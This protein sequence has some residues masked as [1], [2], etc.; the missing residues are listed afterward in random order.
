[1]KEPIVLSFILYALYVLLPLVPTV[2]IY[3]MFPNT[4]VAVSGPLANFSVNATGAFAAYIV[5]VL[6]GW[7]LVSEVADMIRTRERV[8]WNVTGK[9]V[10]T[11]PS[12]G[13]MAGDSQKRKDL[14]KLLQVTV[15]P[16]QFWS[17]EDAI[18]AKTTLNERE[19]T[20]LTYTIP[21]FGS[22][23]RTPN[24]QNASWDYVTHE[25]TFHDPIKIRGWQ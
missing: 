8:S 18:V 3:R 9:L 17:T 13:D 15:V 5:T 19:P 1:M 7:F 12:G 21:H 23:D 16:P 6:L 2:V 25:V 14:L 10:L 22:T 20:T 24:R 4:A 11:D